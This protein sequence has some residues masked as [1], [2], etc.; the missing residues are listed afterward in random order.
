MQ[1]STLTYCITAFPDITDTVLVTKLQSL[2]LSWADNGYLSH[3]VLL[4]ERINK[5]ARSLMRFVR[6]EADDKCSDYF[7]KIE[8]VLKYGSRKEIDQAMCMDCNTYFSSPTGIARECWTEIYMLLL[9]V[10]RTMKIFFREPAVTSQIMNQYDTIVGVANAG[11]AVPTIAHALGH[12]STGIV[13]YHR[14]WQQKRPY[15]DK[16]PLPTN[17]GKVLLCEN[18][19]STGA[20]LRKVVPF[21]IRALETESVDVLFTGMDFDHSRKAAQGISGVDTIM[22]IAEIPCAQ[23]YTNMLIVRDALKRQLANRV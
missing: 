15:W 13:N 19:A 4:L 14:N 6:R 1:W 8:L 22:H 17:G 9:N 3:A 11:V 18:D 2:A 10:R 12:P 20:I 5:S 7:G 16:K 21:V 23:P